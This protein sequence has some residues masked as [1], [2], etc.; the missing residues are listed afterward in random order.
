LIV[1]LL[2]AQIIAAIKAS[3]QPTTVQVNARSAFFTDDVI[4][5][6]DPDVVECGSQHAVLQR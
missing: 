2:L 5:C 4:T 6:K 3:N 1:R